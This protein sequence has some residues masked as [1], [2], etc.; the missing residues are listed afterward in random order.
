MS[1]NL[2]MKH[3][4]IFLCFT[5]VFSSCKKQDTQTHLEL[6]KNWFF[7]DTNESQWLPATVPGTVHTDL[8]QNNIIDDPFYRLN[9]HDVQWID[10]KEWRYRTVLDIN[11]ETLNQ[12]N[13]F[14]EFLGLDTYA[15]ILLNDSCLLKTDNM[16]RVYSIDVKDHLKLGKNNLEVLFDS[17]IK[18]GLEN[19]E[20]LSY[21]IPISGNDLAEIGQVEGNKRVSVFNRKAGYHFGWDWGP[22]LVTSGI[23]KPVILKSWNNFKIEDVYIQQE[24][25]GDIAKL[26]AFV[27]IYFDENYNEEEI[28]LEIKVTNDNPMNE[29]VK[30]LPFKD[31][32]V[33]QV[34]RAYNE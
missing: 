25:K 1:C 6:S 12:Q 21:N 29:L 15:R 9:E 20:K 31:D 28:Y 5:I 23:W 16:F 17:P 7:L 30:V 10:K 34:I 3:I 13:I 4:I 22:R 19:R 14:I 8:I 18:R 32:A 11:A 33:D 24:L 27:E 2:F 26:N